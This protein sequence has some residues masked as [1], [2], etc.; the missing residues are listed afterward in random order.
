MKHHIVASSYGNIVIP[1]PESYS[2]CFILINSDKY[3][4]NG[5]GDD[6]CETTKVYNSRRHFNMV[7]S[8]SI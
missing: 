5:M 4:L 6:F 7:S 2:D 3:R 8:M 1:C